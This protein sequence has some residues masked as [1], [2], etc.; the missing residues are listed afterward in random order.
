VSFCL[1]TVTH[2]SNRNGRMFAGDRSGEWICGDGY[3]AVAL[4]M[5]GHLATAAAPKDYWDFADAGRV[6]FCL[7][8]GQDCLAERNSR[9]THRT[10][11][12]G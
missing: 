3:R 6:S 1:A 11:S 8:C 2:G 5:R 12:K 10:L 9:R 7:Y 4:R